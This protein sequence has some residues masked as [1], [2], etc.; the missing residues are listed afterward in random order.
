VD[1]LSFLAS[2]LGVW[3]IRKPEPIPVEE[4]QNIWHE[5]VEGLHI[6]LNNPVL[7]A[8]AG[9]SGTRYFFGSFFG[10][11]YSF[12]AVR[13]LGLSPALLGVTIAMGGIGALM[14]AFLVERVTQRFG[15]GP[16]LIGSFLLSGFV[17][18]LIPLAEVGSLT[19]SV[20]CL[21]ISQLL[22]DTGLIIFF[23]S[24]VS[25]RQTVIPNRLIGRA[26]ASVHFLVG[27]LATVGALL[28]GVLGGIIGLQLTLLIAVIGMLLASFWIIFSPVASLREMPKAEAVQDL[29]S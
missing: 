5:I 13:E 9:C 8:L 25:L 27:G 18:L 17:Q 29:V 19:F 14:G 2:A 7:R 20:G 3:L 11:L 26:S 15:L 12:Y 6:V 4:R 22:G 10:T 21:M 24:E 28:A 16:T 23:I 1:A